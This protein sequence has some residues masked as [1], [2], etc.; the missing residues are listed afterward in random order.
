MLRMELERKRRY[1]SQRKLAQL[2]SMNQCSVSAVERGREIA[3]PKW[4]RNIADA[5]EW[6]GDPAELFEEVG[7]DEAATVC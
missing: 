4:R 5:L 6:R 3:W 7:E 2:A 1:M